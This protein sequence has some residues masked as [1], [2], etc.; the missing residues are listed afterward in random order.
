MF[1]SRLIIATSLIAVTTA[2]NHPICHEILDSW[3]DR[4]ETLNKL[5]NQNDFDGLCE[6]FDGDTLACNER[7]SDARVA[8][9]QK[10]GLNPQEY[11]SVLG[12]TMMGTTVNKRKCVANYCNHLNDGSC[13]LETTGGQCVWYTKSEVKKLNKE[14]KRIPGFVPFKSQGCYRNP[15]NLPGKELCTSSG[16]KF[17]QC[18]Y[19]NGKGDKRLEGK[20]MGCQATKLNFPTRGSKCAPTN[21]NKV[22]KES[23]FAVVRSNGKKSKKCMCSTSYRMCDILVNKR[24]PT[25]LNYVCRNGQKP[26]VEDGASVCKKGS[27]F[28]Q[29]SNK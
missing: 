27:H 13:D 26:S 24:I 12:C 23:V 11:G 14:G 7:H 28:I 21:S 8:A 22:D 16:N 15:C 9:I 18:T 25:E 19:C 10:Q 17:L 1:A 2:K 3:W 6:K 20:G 4:R 29:T 5:L